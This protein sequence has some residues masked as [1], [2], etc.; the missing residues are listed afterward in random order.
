VRISRELPGDARV[1]LTIGISQVE[2]NM[3]LPPEAFTIDVPPGAM[4]MTLAQLRA[5]GPLGDRE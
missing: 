3:T 2:T 4:P 5:A 1:D